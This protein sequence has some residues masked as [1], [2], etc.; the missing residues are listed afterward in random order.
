MAVVD[1]VVGVEASAAMGAEAAKSHTATAVQA[2]K[3]N[4]PA[5]TIRRA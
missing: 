1:G 5:R 2:H 3:S 4:L